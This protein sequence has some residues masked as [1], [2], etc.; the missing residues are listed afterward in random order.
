MSGTGQ[1]IGFIGLGAMGQ[2]MAGR[3]LGAGFTVRGFDVR[4]EGLARFTAAGG[5]AASRPA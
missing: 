1:R 3:L 4:P 2:G 5:R